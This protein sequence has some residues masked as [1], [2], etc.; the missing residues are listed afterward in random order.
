M[1]QFLRQDKISFAQTQTHFNLNDGIAKRKIV[2]ETTF[3]R[4]Q[5]NP[6]LAGNTDVLQY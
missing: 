1:L 4:I 3:S 2:K 6:L 5:E